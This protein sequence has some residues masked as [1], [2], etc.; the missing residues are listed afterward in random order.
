MDISKIS[1]VGSPK[2]H[3]IYHEDPQQLH[4]GTLEKHCYF[5]PFGTAEDPFDNRERSGRFELLNGEWDF[6]YYETPLELPEDITAA[7]FSEKLTT[8]E[9]GI[10]TELT[11]EFS[12]EGT[13]SA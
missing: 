5:I 4:V 7:D 3:M 12:D 10:N 11:K 2:S 8:L 6:R 13:K 9:K 1:A